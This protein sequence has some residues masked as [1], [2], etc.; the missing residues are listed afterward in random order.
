MWSFNVMNDPSQMDCRRTSSQ[1]VV[2]NGL[3]RLKKEKKKKH[4]ACALFLFVCLYIYIYI[5]ML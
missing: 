5:Y 2:I 1:T 4:Y 3:S